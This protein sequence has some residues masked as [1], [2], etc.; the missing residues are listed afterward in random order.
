MKIAMLGQ[1]YPPMVSG[2]SLFFC[3]LAEAMAARGHE[4][5]VLAASDQGKCYRQHQGDLNIIRLRSY[6]NPERVGQ[7]WLFWPARAI[8]ASLNQFRPEIIHLHDPFQMAY[9]SL[10]YSRK[11]NIPCVIN[12]HGLP[13]MVSAHLPDLPG[14]HDFLEK[15]LWSY[16]TWL[17]RL[18]DA[19]I[20]PT[21]T[22]S[23]LVARR[24]GV[25]T[26]VISYGLDVNTFHPGPLHIR[27]NADLRNEFGIPDQAPIILHTGRL[28]A[29]K[30][31]KAVIQAAAKTIHHLSEKNIHLLIVGDGTEKP[32]LIHLAKELNISEC[33]H[34]PG[35]ITD[36]VKLSAIYRMADLF[37]T[38]SEIETQGLVLLEAAACG[39]PLVAVNASAI[40]EIV[41]DGINGFL[42][43]P[44]EVDAMADRMVAILQDTNLSERMGKASQEVSLAHDFNHTVEAYEKCYISMILNRA[45]HRQVAR[46]RTPTPNPR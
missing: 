22:I 35:Y 8:Q 7:R 29:D 1:S 38:A 30:N 24:T 34:F 5:L 20:T 39:L 31:V 42:T 3:H 17:I 15:G 12:I 11:F 32:D 25:R 19:A 6:P 33:S 27:L 14:A 46:V 21:E 23:N 28:D 13:S 16:A 2:A 37:V 36:P 4:V 9:F 43:Q 44:G 40:P 26:Q 41:T 18:F 45:I 10:K